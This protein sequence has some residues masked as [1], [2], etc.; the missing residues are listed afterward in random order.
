MHNEIDSLSKLLPSNISNNPDSTTL[1]IGNTNNAI[2][3]KNSYK[4]IEN[5]IILTQEAK[6]LQKL[7][8]QSKQRMINLTNKVS[9]DLSVVTQTVKFNTDKTRDNTAIQFA[10]HLATSKMKSVLLSVVTR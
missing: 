1:T 6:H 10:K 3:N 4:N 7:L 9:T 8:S 5:N 2:I